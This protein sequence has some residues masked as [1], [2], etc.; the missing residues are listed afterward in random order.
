MF[1]DGDTVNAIEFHGHGSTS[2][3]GVTADI[4]AVVAKSLQ[5]QLGDQ[6]FD[7]DIDVCRRDLLGLVVQ[8]IVGAQGSR[9]VSRVPHDVG[10]S[11]CQS[12]DRTG[13]EACAVVVD[14]L[15]SPPILLVGNLEGGMGGGEQFRQRCCVVDEGMVSPS[16]EDVLHSEALSSGPVLRRGVSVLSHTEEKV[17]GCADEL[18]NGGLL[19]IRTQLALVEGSVGHG[20]GD[21]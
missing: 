4:G 21:G 3:K 5:A 20:D 18:P 7:F 10:H 13:C 14:A 16:K 15:A 2:T 8:I 17:E 9:R 19:G 11:L 12:F 1:L 6:S